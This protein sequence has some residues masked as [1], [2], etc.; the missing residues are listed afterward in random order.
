MQPFKEAKMFNKKMVS[1]VAVAVLSFSV[2]A[3]LITQD[4]SFG[5]QGSSTDIA[6][7]SPLTQI[8]TINTFDISLG[9]LTGVSLMVYSQIT[10]QGSST[11]NSVAD[12]RTDVGIFLTDDWMVQSSVADDFTFASANSFYALIEAQSAAS[13]LFTMQTGD[14]FE[15][16]ITTGEISSM[17]TNTDISAFLGSNPIDFMF[18]TFARTELR[19]QINPQQGG[20]GSFSN[21]F[22]NAAWGRVVAEFEY[23]PSSVTVAEPSTIGIFGLS[24]AGMALMMRRRI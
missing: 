17:L 2:Q 9:T 11:N 5:T 12:G 15:Y 7:L 6:E 23:T 13:G 10:S 16:D 14:T 24:L 22:S 8:L 19:N 4:V 20:L 3:E 21:S 1:A 18:S